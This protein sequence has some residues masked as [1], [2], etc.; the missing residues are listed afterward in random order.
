M[1]WA[2]EITQQSAGAFQPLTANTTASIVENVGV[3]AV[4]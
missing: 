4:P 3:F 1:I 2:A